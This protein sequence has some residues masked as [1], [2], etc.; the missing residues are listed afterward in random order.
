M[1][2]WS[3]ILKFQAIRRR[4]LY[5]SLLV[6]VSTNITQIP[7]EPASVQFRKDVL[8][9]HQYYYLISLLR[10]YILTQLFSGCRWVRSSAYLSKLCPPAVSLLFLARFECAAW[11]SDCGFSQTYYRLVL[12][13]V[14]FDTM[15]GKCFKC[16][17]DFG[18][19]KPIAKCVEC[20]TEYHPLC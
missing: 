9:M 4:K 5:N 7:I 6:K 13:L 14:L 10:S 12:C 18:A 16:L 8:T 2:Y 1:F 19:S 11:E 20:K 15:P 17:T 3:I